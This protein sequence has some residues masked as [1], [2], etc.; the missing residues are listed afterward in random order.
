L[1]WSQQQLADAASTGLRTINRFE[2][3][4]T[5]PNRATLAVIRQALEKAGV[6]FTDSGGVEPKKPDDI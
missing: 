2:A 4:E 6:R 3:E 5:N 1:A